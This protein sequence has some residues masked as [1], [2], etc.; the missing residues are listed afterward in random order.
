[1][2]QRLEALQRGASESPEKQELLALALEQISEALAALQMAVAGTQSQKAQWQKLHSQTLQQT[3]ASEAWPPTSPFDLP[4]NDPSLTEV[5]SAYPEPPHATEGLPRLLSRDSVGLH[6]LVREPPHRALEGSL[7]LLNTDLERQIQDRTAQLQRALEFEAMLKRV[8][9]NVRDS[10]D[11]SQILQTVVCELVAVLGVECCNTALYDLSSRDSTICYEHTVSIPS[12]QGRVV[13]MADFPE[14]YAQLLRGQ[15]LQ[16]CGLIPVPARPRF[17]ILACPVF[18]DQRAIGDLW[19]LHR[20]DHIFDELEV[21]LVQQVA[22]QCAIA[23]RQARLY[24]AAQ[25]QVQELAKLNRL[26]DD[27]LSTVSHELRTPMANI[28]MAIQMLSLATDE[29]RQARYLE[30]LQTECKREIALINDL[31][32][33]QRLDAGLQARSLISIQLHSWLPQVVQPFRARAQDR[34][35]SLEIA[36]SP[37]LPALVS[38]VSSLERALSELLNN[39]CKYTPPGE[40]ILVMAQVTERP[41]DAVAQMMQLLVINSGVE[42]P[43]DELTCIFDKFY[44]IPGGDPWKQGG[45]GLGLALVKK[46]AEHLG[47]TIEVASGQGNTVFT[48]SLPLS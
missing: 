48:L 23:L 22:N 24:Q 45:T 29:Q 44:R 10:L 18:D 9:D 21:R 42:I 14:I 36:L 2:L 17:A 19:L 32:D 25:A 31:L 16:F 13:A 1:M 27:F 40:Q 11:E 28:K 3:R 26:K 4:S 7:Q 38:D 47:G 35:Q 33:L 39:A 6:W 30:I 43:E 12:A 46:L 41:S 20:K 8:T 37:E 5:A 34:Q 15:H